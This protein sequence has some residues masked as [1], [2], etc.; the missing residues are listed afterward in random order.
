MESRFKG[1]GAKT[2]P[3]PARARQFLE[4]RNVPYAGIDVDEDP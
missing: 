4:A 1:D 2:G 3:E